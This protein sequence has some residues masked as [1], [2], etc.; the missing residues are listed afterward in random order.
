MSQ[1]NCTLLVCCFCSLC[2]LTNEV[3][4]ILLKYLFVIKKKQTLINNGRTRAPAA[5][6]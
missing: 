4:T 1:L 2:Q 5:R 6:I 3:V